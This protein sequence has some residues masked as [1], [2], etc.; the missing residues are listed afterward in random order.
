[1]FHLVHRQVVRFAA[2]AIVLGFLGSVAGCGNDQGSAQVLI[3]AIPSVDARPSS[4]PAL[5]SIEV[6]PS[7]VSVAAGTTAQFTA[8]GVYTDD[9]T[10][11][12]T[13]RVTWATSD[14]AVATVS[15]AVGTHGMA[16]AGSEGTTV[17]SATSGGL[18]GETTLTVT[19]ATLVSIEVTPAAP[20]VASGTTL[21]F[22]ATGLYTDNST[23]DLTTQVA[24]AS[25]DGS[26]ALVGNS[27]GSE[28]LVSAARAGSSS[29]SATNGAVAGETT[30][31]VTVAALVSIEV[32][33]SAPSVASG[34]TLQFTATGLYT[35]NSTQDLTTQVN[36]TSSDAAVATISSGAGS[37]GLATAANTGS[38]TVSANS[39]T[40]S[41][42]ATLTVTDAT[43]VAIEVTP[44]SPSIA[45]GLTQQFTATG[46]YSDNSTQDITSRV[47]WASADGAVATVSNAV[48]SH[49]LATAAGVGSTTVSASSG[50]LTG[51]TALIVT[52]ATLVSIEVSPAIPSIVSGSA[53]QFSATGRYTDDS[54]LD[55]T[56]QVTWA[57]SDG[58]V[59]TI[60]NAAGS[61]G[62]ATSAGVGSTTVS[63]SSGDVT[64]ETTLT[65]TDAALLSIEVTPAAPVVANGLT[66]QFAATGH[67]SDGSTQDVT[68]VVTWATSDAAVATV[69][70][71][72]GSNGLASTNGIG[73]TTVSASSGDV[74][75]TATF[76]VTDATLVSIEVTPAAPSVA[77]GLTQQFTATGVYTDGTTQDITTGVV[78][79]SS[80]GTVATV[81]NAPGSRGLATT[82]GPGST[83]VSATSGGV[84]GETTLTV[85]SAGLVWID[86]SPVMPSIASGSTQQFNATGHYTDNSTQDLTAQVLW[87]SSDADVATVS[88]AAGSHGL[89]TAIAEGS[90]DV[91][92]VHGSVSGGTMLTVTAALP[93]ADDL[94]ADLL[95]AVTGVGPGQSLANKV[96]LVQSY[97]AVPDIAAACTSLTDF[98]LQLASMSGKQVAVALAS[99]LTSDAE[100]IKDSIPCP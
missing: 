15:N 82:T 38:T 62:L 31:T 35:D 18:V 28:G 66:Q 54:T 69:S 10:S 5:K 90:T 13:T 21:Q 86:V 87:D 4:A 59:A 57:S 11:D 81:G 16:V 72:A 88:N 94:V 47:T 92:A 30:L 93:S 44:S 68:A 52:G 9:S 77:S 56:D 40:V 73:S 36:W 76:T 20:S 34:T 6:T 64:G 65:V 41:G 63:A 84:S 19:D 96:T 58:A 60:S 91:S 42:E 8:T 71:A 74:S 55:I 53:Q 48:G 83:T 80:D 29:I 25:S 12:L 61:R 97:L 39:G 89:A 27:V 70:N 26:V 45:S 17:V 37:N 7:L 51:T 24:W 50:N 23:Q 1:L 79:A 85:T 33:P 49:G 14:A 75:G 99:Q 43:L 100:A 32:A 95:V 46:L 98:Q 78:W 2:S 3:P 67:Y 22:T